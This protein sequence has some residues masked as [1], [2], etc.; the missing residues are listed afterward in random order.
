MNFIILDKKDGKPI[1]APAFP[2]I[3]EAQNHIKK[4]KNFAENKVKAGLD[5]YQRAVKEIDDFVIV[6]YEEYQMGKDK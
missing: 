6:G 3:K 1:P 2:N 5:G 4:L